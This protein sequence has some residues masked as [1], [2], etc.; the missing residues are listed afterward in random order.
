MEQLLYY[1]WKHKMFPPGQLFTACG[2]AVEVIDSG[3]RNDNSGPDF[4]NAK[5][6]IDGTMWVGNVE[7]HDRAADWYVHGHD[8]DKAY[9]NVVLHVVGQTGADTMTSGGR[10]VPQLRLDVP[11]EVARNYRELLTEE[12]YPPCYRLIPQLPRITAHGWLG[13]LQAERLERKTVDIE[14]RVERCGGCWESALF[15]TMARNYGFGVNG[16]AFEAWAY[17]IPL[18]AAAHH[19][20][21][22]FQIEALFMGQAGLLDINT[23]P[24]RYREAALGEGYF[25]ELR[26]EYAF[27][28]HK[29]GLKPID[30]GLWRFLRLRPQNFP[31]I[32]ISQLASLYHSRRS[33]LSRLM[34][35]G[36]AGRMRELLH[37]NVTPYWETHYVFGSEGSRRSKSVSSFSLDVVIINTVAPMLFAYGRH[38][39]DGQLCER[40]LGLLAQLRPENNAVVRSWRQCGLEAE[41]AGDTQALIQLKNEYCDKKDCLRCRIGYFF[42]NS[43]RKKN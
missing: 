24:S 34:E 5:V 37:T 30:A 2:Q 13:R 11:E 28:A 8:K 40:A 33:D 22:I 15:V 17:N 7:I 36:D 27:L 18:Q 25:E 29:F 20:D 14:R 32:R 12:H 10:R 35:C 3:L 21:D 1:V 31:Y 43:L 23:V 39:H 16:D 26:R 42:L 9:D 4:F 19:R 6:C 38:R 41:N